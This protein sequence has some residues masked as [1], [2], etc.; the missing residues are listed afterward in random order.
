LQI[1]GFVN[2]FVFGSSEDGNGVVVQN[3]SSGVSDGH[4]GAWDIEHNFDVFFLEFT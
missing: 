3:D 1:K 2:G 4:G